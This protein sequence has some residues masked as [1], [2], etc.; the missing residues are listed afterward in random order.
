MV[1]R[2]EPAPEFEGEYVD[3]RLARAK[4]LRFVSAAT[5]GMWLP[6]EHACRCGK[7]FELILAPRLSR[8]DRLGRQMVGNAAARSHGPDDQPFGHEAF[9][10]GK[11][12]RSRHG[13]IGRQPPAR[14]Q[15]GT[16]RKIAAEDGVA[17]AVVDLAAERDVAR[18]I[19]GHEQI[20]N[21][22]MSGHGSVSR[23][24]PSASGLADLAGIG[25]VCSEPLVWSRSMF[26]RTLAD[27]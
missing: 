1:P 27:H 3:G 20:G 6:Q 7:P 26:A 9:V 23:R 22:P 15:P 19:E 25:L 5:L 8:S 13:E 4:G 18:R 12:R 16:R 2:R 17:Q 11:N 24:Y 10:R 21:D 14:W